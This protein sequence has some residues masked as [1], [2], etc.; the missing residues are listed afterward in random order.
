M[1]Y[2][3]VGSISAADWAEIKKLCK[4]MQDMID[5]KFR[6]L[7]AGQLQIIKDRIT[8]LENS[9]AAVETA[10]TLRRDAGEVAQARRLAEEAERTARAELEMSHTAKRELEAALQ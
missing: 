2:C 5:Q 4:Q 9:L 10:A 3:C 7:D 1:A 8:A 6:D